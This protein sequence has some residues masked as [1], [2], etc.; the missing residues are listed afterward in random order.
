MMAIAGGPARV[1]I[2]VLTTL[3]L[4]GRP[5]DVMAQAPLAADGW[6][7]QVQCTLSV[8]AVGYQDTQTHLWTLSGAPPVARSGFRDYPA[9]WTIEGGGRRT[10]L[11]GV[12]GSF[13]E[14]WTRGGTDAN[15]SITI[16]EPIGTGGLRI[17]P[18]QRPARAMNGFTTTLRRT[19]DAV[20][21]PSTMT[22]Y[23]DG[24]RFPYIQTVVIGNTM[25]GTRTETRTGVIGWRQPSTAPVTET[26][27]WNFTRGA[28]G[29]ISRAGRQG[30]AEVAERVAGRAGG[31][32]NANMTVVPLNP[33]L[34]PLAT[35]SPAA[36]TIALAGFTARGEAVAAPPRAIAVNGFTAT[37]SAVSVSPRSIALTGFAA[38]GDAAAVPARAITVTGWTAVGAN[39]IAPRGRN[40]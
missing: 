4:V 30:S 16:F 18:G 17:A 38:H 32:A 12:S 23:V 34:I 15:A 3:L 2:G 39:A 26:C 28:A 13:T 1:F 29:S 7:G 27:T 33:A 35:I 37:G 10:S 5:T 31:A 14:T 19:G 20:T 8:S 25:V 40:E 6:S 22:S 24:W 21:S 9:T 36:R 11:P